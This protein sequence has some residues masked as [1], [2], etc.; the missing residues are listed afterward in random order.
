MN[1]NTAQ[2]FIGGWC[3][4]MLSVPVAFFL[5]RPDFARGRE[6]SA[7]MKL[8][9]ALA[10]VSAAGLAISYLISR[11]WAQ[12]TRLLQQFVSALPAS[13][14]ALSGRG[15]EELESLERAMRSMGDRVRQVVERASL[16][17]SRRETILACMAE[18]V[19]A[20]DQ[21]LKVIFCNDAFAAAFGTRTPVAEGRSLYEVV[22]EPALRDILE[23]VVNGGAAEK[24]LLRLPSAAGRSFE[25]RALSLGEPRRGAV[26]ALHDVTDIE[27]QEQARKDF[28][29]DV[30]HELRTPLTA[31]R[32]YAETLLD[33][34]LEDQANNRKFVEI[35]LAH[36]VRLNNIASD[37]LVLSEL[38]S[39]SGH[40][41]PPERVRVL[42]VV[43]SAFHTVGSGAHILGVRLVKD[44]CEDCVVIGHRFRLQQ[45]LVNLMDNAVKFN[46]PDGEVCVECA[47]VADGQVRIS[48]AD[49]GIGIP[50]DDLKRIFERFYRV[51]KAR[52]RRAGGTGLG[53]P[54]VKQMV[55]R[56]GGAI[57]VESQLGRGSKFSVLLKG[58]YS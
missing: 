57:S 14:L 16:E 48:V 27:R 50:S 56:M 30:S 20:V 47:Q 44:Q 25:V 52:S 3:A 33:G 45:V 41:M 8:F 9:V 6:A 2:K 55:E 19:L 31:I 58:A 39:S 17:L 5:L 4:L 35:I 49:T 18:G 36:S 21:N 15:P 23:R 34:A 24:D 40:P 28:V 10:I 11:R 7:L 53:L 29:A 54:I 13:T 12:R 43:E 38:D 51:D 42:E 37:L 46:R 22:R 1:G 26:I 32:G